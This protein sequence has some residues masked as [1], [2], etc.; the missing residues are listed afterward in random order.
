MLDA[1]HLDVSS[2]FCHQAKFSERAASRPL[3]TP[4]D[5]LLAGPMV[6]LVTQLKNTKDQVELGPCFPSA[7]GVDWRSQIPFVLAPESTE[8]WI[9]LDVLV[10]TKNETPGSANYVVLRLRP[11]FQETRSA[12]TE[13]VRI[14]PICVAM[15]G[16][17]GASVNCDPQ[18][19]SA[20]SPLTRRT[21]RL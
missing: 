12:L 2:S 10:G 3:A 14:C 15:M 8:I 11:L 6:A 7:L 18:W 13:Q 5:S 20:R 1:S 17:Q 4:Q 19:M 16:I 21:Q 9:P